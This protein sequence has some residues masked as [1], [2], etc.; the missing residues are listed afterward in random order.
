MSNSISPEPHE[1]LSLSN[2]SHGLSNTLNKLMATRERVDSLLENASEPQ[3]P[4]AGMSDA[5]A[6]TTAPSF[7]L[8]D[9]PNDG[10]D[11]NAE[12]SAEL[13]KQ[14]D[15][16][17]TASAAVIADHNEEMQQHLSLSMQEGDAGAEISTTDAR[18]YE[19]CGEV[20]F[21]PG[22]S[23][24]PGPHDETNAGHSVVA[25]VS[26]TNVRAGSSA[27]SPRAP[28][29]YQP[30]GGSQKDTDD[31]SLTI[32]APSVQ[33]AVVRDKD[34][35]T[36]AQREV[37]NAQKQAAEL[38]LLVKGLSP[39]K[40]EP[41]AR[42][43]P[44]TTIST[45]EDNSNISGGMPAQF[46]APVLTPTHEFF[47]SKNAAGRPQSFAPVLKPTHAFFQSQNAAGSIHG[48]Q[49]TAD[50]KS[51]VLVLTPPKSSPDSGTS[52]ATA[53]AAQAD[54]AKHLN[55]VRASKPRLSNQEEFKRTREALASMHLP[56]TAS[57]Q[58]MAHAVELV[59]TP[60]SAL[61]ANAIASATGSSP[62]A[63]PL[64]Q[65]K[66]REDSL[67]YGPN[68]VDLTFE[69]ISSPNMATTSTPERARPRKDSLFHGPNAVRTSHQAP[70]SRQHTFSG[71]R[72]QYSAPVQADGGFESSDSAAYSQASNTGSLNLHLNLSEWENAD[73][74]ESSF[75]GI[76]SRPVD[77]TSDSFVERR[78][79][80]SDVNSS[81]P[82][83]PMT[84]NQVP[85]VTIPNTQYKELPVPLEPSV[86]EAHNT[87]Y[88]DLPSP[89]NSQSISSIGVPS[90]SRVSDGSQTTGS[91][92]SSAAPPFSDLIRVPKTL[93]SNFCPVGQ[94]TTVPLRLENVTDHWMECSLDVT[95]ERQVFQF[96]N[97]HTML[98]RP[99]AVETLNIVFAPARS[100]THRAFVQI[101]AVMVELTETEPRPI[102][103]RSVTAVAI[104]GKSNDATTGML[105]VHPSNLGFGLIS[106][107][108]LHALP[109]DLMNRGSDTLH[110]AAKVITF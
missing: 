18:A 94:N 95:A 45:P 77:T 14:I 2:S 64:G 91:R 55:T 16:L 83:V 51:P 36:H 90:P 68:A 52:A 96:N 33:K 28:R 22:M 103:S 42:T 43:P 70:S 34:V 100:G 102:G 71:R 40:D 32:A 15:A 109:I 59:Q 47:Q 63:T 61:S 57:K 10:G 25:N 105:E 8:Y 66:K 88:M 84:P 73:L 6:N 12:E 54:A 98:L 104:K 110:I 5:R 41:V 39:A 30:S 37:A 11:D 93:E 58:H 67:F 29:D 85:Q 74:S 38:A 107:K 44:P 20:S 50:R 82:S 101:T 78:S 75:A 48:A 89:L 72:P 56:A 23:N 79:K 4:V 1:D 65:A 21:A 69:D 80:W 99:H 26:M 81:Q 7:V 62:A 17:V 60:F 87:Q 49:S 24:Q 86:L 108:A 46:F 106:S 3:S 92:A 35:P 97:P 27:E 76:A 31:A 53:Q 13:R 9:E 19:T